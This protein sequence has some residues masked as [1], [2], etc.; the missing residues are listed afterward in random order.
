MRFGAFVPQGWRWDLMEIPKSD[1]WRII[2]DRAKL[3]ERSGFESLWV[4]DHFHNW[5]PGWWKEQREGVEGTPDPVTDVTYEAWTMMA[6]LGAVTSTVRLGQMCTCNTYRPPAY[7]AK[8]AATIDVFTGGRVEMGIGAGWYEDEHHGYGY[9]Y[10]PP[11]DRLRMLREGIEIMKA[12][13]T[14]DEVDYEGRFYK[15]EGGLGDP[16]PV[17]QPHI[18]VWVAGGGEQVTLRIAARHADYTNFGGDVETFRRKSE[19]LRQHCED[20]GTD[21]DRI[22]RSGIF[23]AFLGETEA[24]AQDKI[25]WLA[26]RLGKV[27]PQERADQF[28]DQFR[29]MT[30]TPEQVVERLKAYE[31]E[32]MSYAILNFADIAY[33]TSSLELFATRVI[34]ELS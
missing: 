1:H 12:F 24:E 22:V 18:P 32:G 29:L 21:Y 30:G 13:W 33:D 23:S 17:Q 16:K 9:E 6:A 34:P 11:K 15:I 26:S 4:Y 14:Q 2:E 25:S 28:V 8:V 19:I 5:P 10:L 3:I 31:A 7:L 27:M 20:L